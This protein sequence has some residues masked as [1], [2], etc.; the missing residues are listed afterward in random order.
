VLIKIGDTK[1]S[2]DIVDL[3]LECHERIL[4]FSGLACRLATADAPS[5]DEVRDAA[6][7]IVRYFSQSLPL[8]VADEE[9][10]VVPR[11]S[12]RNQDIDSALRTMHEEHAQHEP[13]LKSLL[14]TCRQLEASPQRLP[15]FR[16]ALRSTTSVLQ[17]KFVAHLQLEEKVILP[18]IRT[19]LTAT[20]RDA[21]VRELRAR[22]KSSFA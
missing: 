15:E 5:E 16:E 19:L 7:R 2:S 1:E 22:R 13:Y 12:G 21:M 9:E 18:A 8:H 4:A 17:D 10:S 20:D 11:L 6:A 3:L 14:E